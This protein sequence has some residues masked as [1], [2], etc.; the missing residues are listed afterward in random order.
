MIHSV[1]VKFGNNLFLIFTQ[2]AGERT[3]SSSL[4][5]LSEIEV[6]SMMVWRKCS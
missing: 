3:V 4:F 1:I 5:I 2:F 6:A